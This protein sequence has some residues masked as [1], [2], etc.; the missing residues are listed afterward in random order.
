MN[1]KT[2]SIYDPAMCCSTGVCGPEV[3]PKL[4]RFSADLEWLRSSGVKVE[5]FNLAQE[6]GAFASTPL[7]KAAL[8]DA[9]EAA[10]PIFLVDGRLVMSG[11]YPTRDQLG[12][13]TGAIEGAGAAT[14]SGCCGPSST[15]KKSSCC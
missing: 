14:A 9:G 5:R 4:V 3:D 6:P 15:S 13:W 1:T 8:E 2:L 7:V 12:A 11:T 10:L